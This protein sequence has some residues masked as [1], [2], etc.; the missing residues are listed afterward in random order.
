MIFLDLVTMLTKQGIGFAM[1]GLFGWIAWE[2]DKEVQKLS[3]R[4]LSLI[5]M[6]QKVEQIRDRGPGKKG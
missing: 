6:Q 3:L 2:K 5:T 1:A 4:M